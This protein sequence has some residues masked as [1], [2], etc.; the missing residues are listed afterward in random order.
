MVG[1]SLPELCFLLHEVWIRQWHKSDLF[2]SSL[3]ALGEVSNVTHNALQNSLFWSCLSLLM[4]DEIQL[5]S[6]L[7]MFITDYYFWGLWDHQ[8][9]KKGTR[10]SKVLHNH[11]LCFDFHSKSVY[12]SAT[13]WQVNKTVSSECILSV[14]G[15]PCL[16]HLISCHRAVWGRNYPELNP[17]IFF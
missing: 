9:M 12:S 1:L 10:H 7:I 15:M 2:T 8:R 3:W 17:Q 16:Q 4:R 11:K 5:Q 14:R 6:W 13:A